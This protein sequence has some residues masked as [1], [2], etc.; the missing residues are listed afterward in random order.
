MVKPTHGH[1]PGATTFGDGDVL[2]DGFEQSD[3]EVPLPAYVVSEPQRLSDDRR[4][5]VP[6]TVICTEFSGATLR[7]WIGDGL[8]PVRE[9]PKIAGV[10][11]VDMPTGQWPQFTRPADLGWAIAASI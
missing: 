3:G 11:Y 8:T 4:Y 1:N 9:F 6:V 5:A 7:K 10:T 2:A